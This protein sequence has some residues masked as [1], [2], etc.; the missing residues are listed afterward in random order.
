MTV[1]INPGGQ[2]P[3]GILGAHTRE[4]RT[5]TEDDANFLRAVANVLASAIERERAEEKQRF[6]ADAGA[7]L[8]SSL[9]Y[10]T[11]LA[12]V[13]RLAVPA[14]ADWCAVDVL[15]NG[16][17]ERL[18]VEHPDPDK[19]ALAMKL[20]ERY[21]PDPDA[22]GGVPH[23]LRTGRPEFYVEITEEMLEAAAVDGGHL[24]IL[25]EIGF[26]SAMVLPMNRAREDARRH[27]PGLGRVGP[28]VRAGGPGPRRGGRPQGGACGGQRQALR[29]GPA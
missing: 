22:P 10:R 12:S 27:N 14:L 7:L 17:V 16:S 21:P 26:T 23:V 19:V 24:E 6:L 4:H 1:I 18:A 3:F 2:Q 9:D 29:G 28:Q 5:F 11:T 20:Q 15:E 25:R 8:T 13:A